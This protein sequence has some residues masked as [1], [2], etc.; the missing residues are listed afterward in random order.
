LGLQVPASES[1][2]Q[3]VALYGMLGTLQSRCTQQSGLALPSDAFDKLSD[4]P[5]LLSEEIN[6]S[7]AGDAKV[8]A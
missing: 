5:A 8:L 2:A 7:D 1:G 6:H 4:F 3:Q